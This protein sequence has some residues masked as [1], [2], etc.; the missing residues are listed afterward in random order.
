MTNTQALSAI[1]TIEVGQNPP[2][3]SISEVVRGVPLLRRPSELG[4]V[5][6]R[7]TEWTDRPARV[8]RDGDLLISLRGAN[9]GAVNRADRDYAIGRGIG[10]IRLGRQLSDQAFLFYA[11]Q[12]RRPQ[13]RALATGAAV[14]NISIND[15]SSLAVP[16]PAAA[17]RHA[18]A[19]ALIALDLKIKRNDVTA[20]HLGELV[21]ALFDRAVV[22]PT[23]ND[24]G[25]AVMT[26]RIA[27]IAQDLSEQT[28]PGHSPD[29][30]F[31]YYNL[32][33]YSAGRVPELVPG[34]EIRSSKKRVP[35]DAVLV[36]LLNPEDSKIWRARPSGTAIPVASTE[37][38]VLTASDPRDQP[39]LEAYMRF[40]PEL[41][42]QILASIK[43]G[44]AG[45]PRASAA[46]VRSATIAW[47]P[48][49]ERRELAAQLGPVLE[50]EDR[51]LRENNVLHQLKDAVQS[52]LL[53]T[54][55]AAPDL[56]SE[57]SDYLL[58]EWAGH[59]SANAS[60]DGRSA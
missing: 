34:R 9:L 38:M 4:L 42:E 50:L 44:A 55:R 22:E 30:L 40:D 33:A 5:H 59:D 3:D 2:A 23:A 14:P 16:W 52:E 27:D 32:A 28:E 47:L 56:G 60:D 53:D 6:P 19:T 26:V 46:A 54:D 31:E 13:L 15:V 12:Q 45:R 51:L 43:P 20:E 1:T 35:S 24:E 58:R 17:E 18:C 36:A 48:V 41:R 10:A 37:F 11:L 49:S 39:L 8:A 29:E 57:L 25:P 21:H 7:T